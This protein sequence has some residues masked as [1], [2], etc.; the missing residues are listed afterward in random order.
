M[1]TCISSKLSPRWYQ[2]LPEWCRRLL[3]TSSQ[4]RRTHSLSQTPIRYW[5]RLAQYL[6]TAQLTK[7]LLAMLAMM[8]S[9]RPGIEC[10]AMHLPAACSAPRQ[11]ACSHIP[12]PRRRWG[13]APRQTHNTSYWHG[14]QITCT[15][16]AWISNLNDTNWNLSFRNTAAWNCMTNL[17]LRVE[18]N[19]LCWWNSD[20]MMV[21]IMYWQHNSWRQ[22][23]V[24]YRQFRD[25]SHSYIQQQPTMWWQ[26]MQ[27]S[28]N[29][30]QLSVS[31]LNGVLVLALV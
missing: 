22:V 21:C 25:Q 31:V 26:L 27:C 16:S 7:H 13:K 17:F 5:Q 29:S 2:Q 30:T 8:T 9:G 28:M 4:H 24:E 15:S 6:A 14:T 1:V 20:N 3:V 11:H 23:Q 19:G 12:R 10:V 18:D